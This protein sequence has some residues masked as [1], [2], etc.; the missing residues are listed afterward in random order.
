MNCVFAGTFDPITTGHT[1][2]IYTCIKLFDKTIIAIAKNDK[3]QP[4]LTVSERLDLINLVYGT[5]KKVEIAVVDSAIADF[6]CKKKAVYVRGIRNATDYEYESE[7]FYAN[8]SINADFTQI[9][10]PCEQGK[11]HISSSFVKTLM[12]LNKPYQQYLPN[13]IIK[14]FEKF[15]SLKNE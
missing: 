3:K 13:E 10:I 2:V 8:K 6:V 7:M 1:A 5:N 14:E 15:I 12:K 9:Y 11:L 4:L